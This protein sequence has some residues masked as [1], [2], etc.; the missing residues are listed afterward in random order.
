MHTAG[1]LGIGAVVIPG[2]QSLC[3]LSFLLAVFQQSMFYCGP[4]RRM[5]GTWGLLLTFS[6]W[7]GHR[8]KVLQCLA[9]QRMTRGVC[10][11]GEGDSDGDVLA[12]TRSLQKQQ[13]FV[14]QRDATGQ[15]DLSSLPNNATGRALREYAAQCETTV[16][17]HQAQVRP[18]FCCS[19]ALLHYSRWP[20]ELSVATLC[21]F[22]TVLCTIQVEIS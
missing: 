9:A 22:R 7:F 4:V 10:A 16:Q 1:P 5:H 13:S 8:F 6:I 12:V 14:V 17:V 15:L 19:K 2:T 18:T 20:P 3:E 21:P 11:G